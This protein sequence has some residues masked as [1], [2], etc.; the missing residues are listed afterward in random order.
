MDD[1]PVEPSRAG[2]HEDTS[3]LGIKFKKKSKKTEQFIRVVLKRNNMIVRVTRDIN[4]I[5]N[6]LYFSGIQSRPEQTRAVLS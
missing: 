2:K 4:K 6:V 1:T 5:Y 3:I